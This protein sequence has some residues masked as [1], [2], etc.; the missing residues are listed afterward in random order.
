MVLFHDTGDD[1]GSD[2]GVDDAAVVLMNHILK[3]CRG[4]HRS[5]RDATVL[6]FGDISTD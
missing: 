3:T 6:S 5:D 1:G 2:L 4:C